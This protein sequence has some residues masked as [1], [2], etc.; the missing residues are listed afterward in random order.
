MTVVD[1]MLRPYTE[2]ES[3][4]AA[5]L[6]LDALTEQ[7]DVLPTPIGDLYDELA[8]LAADE[9]DFALA[10]RVQRKAL[11]A[12]CSHPNLGRE[13]LGWYLLKLGDVTAGEAAF[14]EARAQQP[15]DSSV[16]ITLGAAR[17]DAGLHQAA[18]EAYDEAVAIALLQDSP[19]AVDRARIERRSYR[20]DQGLPMDADDRLAPAPRSRSAFLERT[21]WAV[22]WFP[23][24]QRELA[25]QRWPDLADDLSTPGYDRR[26]EG[27]LRGMARTLGERP[28]VAPIDPDELERFSADNGLVADSGEARS[29]FVADLARRGATLPWPPGRNEPCWCQ[30][31]RKYKRCCGA[32]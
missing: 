27:N 3:L 5:E 15:E 19:A 7:A 25:L 31:G 13:M 24:H 18:M 12:G 14:A 30:S 28:R 4:D 20:E 11:D 2:A 16:L 21:A 23:S 8:E 29:R 32:D 9:E 22:A 17:A 10:A 6:A 26:I 1:D